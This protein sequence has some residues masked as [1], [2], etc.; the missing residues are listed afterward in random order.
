MIEKVNLKQVLVACGIG[1]A[2]CFVFGV[3]SKPSTTID[4]LQSDTDGN[5]GSIKVN[6][7]AVGVGIDRSEAH[8][9]NAIQAI[10]RTRSEI[11]GS[12]EAVSNL[13]E[14]IRKLESILAKCEKLTGESKAIIERVDGA[15]R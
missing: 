10:E 13:N 15:N 4:Q 2:L 14:G 5:L 6:T 3:F 11:T 9:T 12:R 7:S 8:N 1:L